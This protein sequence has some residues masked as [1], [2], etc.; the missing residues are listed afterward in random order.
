VEVVKDNLIHKWRAKV[1][2]GKMNASK[3]ALTEENIGMRSAV[4]L[5]TSAKTDMI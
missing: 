3:L 1:T 5:N 4:V 2:G